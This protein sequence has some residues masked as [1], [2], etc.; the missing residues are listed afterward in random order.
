MTTDDFDDFNFPSADDFSEEKKSNR[1]PR[2]IDLNDFVSDDFPD[3]PR[4]PRGG[5]VIRQASDSVP[6]IRA[7]LSFEQQE[8]LAKMVEWIEN[9]GFKSDKEQVP[10]V[11]FRKDEDR[12]IVL[13]GGTGASDSV[14]DIISEDKRNEMGLD[15]KISN[16][17]LELGNFKTNNRKQ[18]SYKIEDF[19]YNLESVINGGNSLEELLKR[20]CFYIAQKFVS[21]NLNMKVKDVKFSNHRTFEKNEE[22][23]AIVTVSFKMNIHWPEGM[24]VGLLADKLKGEV[25]E[26]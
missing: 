4:F 3:R 15:C 11:Q 21:Y 16:I 22:T 10:M 19:A 1:I 24:G 5:C 14:F 9:G 20:D 25:V 23:F 13:G 8:E 2:I 6:F 7:F 17:D 18:Q 26:D 12:L